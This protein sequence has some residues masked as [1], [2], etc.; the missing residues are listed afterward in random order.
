MKKTLAILLS[1]TLTSSLLLI[2]PNS[3]FAQTSQFDQQRQL[4]KHQNQQF[5]LNLQKKKI[6]RQLDK[7]RSAQ[8]K[9]RHKSFN[10]SSS[11]QRRIYQKNQNKF[12]SIRKRQINS[13]N[14]R[15]HNQKELYQIR[16]NQRNNLHRA[17][18]I[19]VGG[20]AKRFLTGEV[21]RNYKSFGSITRGTK[22]LNTVRG[23]R[24][25]SE[26]YQNTIRKSFGLTNFSRPVP[27]Y[28]IRIPY[29]RQRGL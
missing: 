16:N 8:Y 13:Y 7:I 9:N 10:N 2:N 19:G 18:N 17:I 12:Q 15:K 20:N 5:K 24:K 4:R 11:N 22:V 23:A 3:S 25:A 14:R 6:Q 29:Q 1:V 21:K 27:R 28:N 26:H